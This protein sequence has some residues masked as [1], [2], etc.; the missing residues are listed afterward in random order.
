MPDSVDDW[1]PLLRRVIE[2]LAASDVT[3]LELAEGDFRVRLRRSTGLSSR[4]AEPAVPDDSLD[5]SPISAPFTGIFY[6]AA[7][8]TAEPYAREG[9]WVEAGA[10]V[11]LIETMKIFNEVRVEQAGQIARVLAAN[12]QLVQAGDPLMIV[13]SGEPQ[14]ETPA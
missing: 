8:P 3:E 12:G 13:T 11:G 10:I 14:D 9:D 2:D 4:T 1:L 6:R 5:G 7:T